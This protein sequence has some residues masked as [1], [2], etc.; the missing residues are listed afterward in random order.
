MNTTNQ[1]TSDQGYATRF[2]HVV[3]L[4]IEL[5]CSR[6][7]KST[8]LGCLLSLIEHDRIALTEQLK[9]MLI[10]A[11]DF[12]QLFAM[13]KITYYKAYSDDI[14]K[15]IKS[16]SVR[17]SS[18][19]VKAVVTL[20]LSG[21]PESTIILKDLLC[22]RDES[23]RKVG[24]IGY[25]ML[26][27]DRSVTQ[28]LESEWQ[29]PMGDTARCFLALAILKHGSQLSYSFLIERARRFDDLSV[30]IIES[31]LIAGNR[32]GFG[33]L[34]ELISSAEYKRDPN[35]P[36]AVCVCVFNILDR[37]LSTQ[38]LATWVDNNLSP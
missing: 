12:V 17:Q 8:L 29:T 36:A 1:D 38:E 2:S 30:T 20:C 5:D 14:M 35:L 28:L 16:K 27:P 3:D 32:D 34:K 4:V 19:Q 25:S 10:Y 13:T 6:E 11:A 33:L 31:L 26:A 24:Y 15:I 21:N 9:K 22:N 37:V 18:V 7:S 23:Q